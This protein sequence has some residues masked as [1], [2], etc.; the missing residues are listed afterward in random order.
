MQLL[1]RPVDLLSASQFA[2]AVHDRRRIEA[3]ICRRLSKIPLDIS[4]DW[5]AASATPPEGLIFV[6]RAGEQVALPRRLDALR[7]VIERAILHAL[8]LPASEVAPSRT[9]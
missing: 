3:E 6:N 7:A 8:A 4:F 5:T 1:I 9:G 2:E